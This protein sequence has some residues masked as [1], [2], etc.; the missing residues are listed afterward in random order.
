MSEL[1]IRRPD[2]RSNVSNVLGA[3]ATATASAATTAT[4]SATFTLG[5]NTASLAGFS[6][7]DALR[8]AADLG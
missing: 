3:P 1:A 5:V 7:E 6:L 4:A 2:V 8:V